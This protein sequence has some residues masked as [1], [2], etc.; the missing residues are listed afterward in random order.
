MEARAS[1]PVLFAAL[2]GSQTVAVSEAGA[3]I[4]RH[5]VPDSEYVVPDGDYPAVVTLFP[6]DDC[7][8]SLIHESYLLTVAHCAVDLGAGDSLDVS[9]ASHVIAEVTLH[10][11]W[12]DGDTFDIAVVRF[13]EPVVGVDPI[14]IYRGSDELGAIVTLV[15][16]GVTETGLVGESGASSDGLLRRATN[17]VTDADDH[18]LEFFFDSPDDDDV[19][20]LEG[21]GASGDSG[22]PVFIEV[23][24]TRYIAGLNSYGDGDGGIGVGEYGAWDYQARVSRYA[25][26]VD[27]VLDEGGSSSTGG[28]ETSSGADGSSSGTRDPTTTGLGATSATGDTESPAPAE[29]G[30][31]GCGC[32]YTRG[33]PPWWLALVVLGARRRRARSRRG[34]SG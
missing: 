32:A 28:D 21:V 26:W 30:D 31:D 33:S 20:D 24:G 23:D 13:E 7:M 19:T 15:G 18:V 5:D 1:I 3:I 27:S 11:E 4:I 22:G 25:D 6:P 34:A 16:R 9:G 2:V 8:G 14:P 12:T 17:L 10:P 29:D